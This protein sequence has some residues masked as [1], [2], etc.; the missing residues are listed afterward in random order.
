MW[1]LIV[2]CARDGA[3][4]HQL[5]PDL[6]EIGLRIVAHW[7]ESELRTLLYG[8]VEVH[9][10]RHQLLVDLLRDSALNELDD[11]HGDVE[12]DQS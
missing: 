10:I 8:E 2:E 6:Q 11:Q 9:E 3:D 12:I 7:Q 1:S 4:A 5:A